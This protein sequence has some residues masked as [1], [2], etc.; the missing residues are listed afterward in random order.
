MVGVLL[1]R[2]PQ[3]TPSESCQDSHKRAETLATGSSKPSAGATTAPVQETPSEEP[4]VEEPPVME[5]P[6]TEAPATH[7]DTPAPMETGRD[8]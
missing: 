6:V 1:P 3:I 7:S 8:R 2:W 5:T 4:P